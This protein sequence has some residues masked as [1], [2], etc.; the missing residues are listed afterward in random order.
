MLA[1]PSRPTAIFAWHDTVAIN[2]LAQAQEMSL[3]VPQDLAVVGYDNFHI[4]ALP[5]L[6]RL[7][8]GLEF[9]EEIVKVHAVILT[10]K[11]PA[12]A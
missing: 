10:E 4:S 7:E 9:S 1:A 11:K 12:E 2:V 6:Q 8:L 3:R 5:Q